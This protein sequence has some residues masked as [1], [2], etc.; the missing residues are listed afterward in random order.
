MSTF[1]YN[2]IASVERF[3]KLL[4]KTKRDSLLSKTHSSVERSA[5]KITKGQQNLLAVERDML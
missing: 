2:I 3:L 5:Y 4:P 1:C